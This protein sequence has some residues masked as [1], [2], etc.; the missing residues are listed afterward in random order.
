MSTCA[1]I[2]GPR[3]GRR[4][5]AVIVVLS[6][7][8]GAAGCGGGG[9]KSGT[10]KSASV[11]AT[12]STT[13]QPGTSSPGS[14]GHRH[15]SKKSAHTPAKTRTTSQ[16]HTTGAGASSTTAA[17]ASSNSSVHH[18]AASTGPVGP[19]HATL[20]APNHDPTANRGWT[21]SL[22]VKDGRGQPLSGTV[23]VEFA[24]GGKVVGRD[25]PPTHSF[26]NGEWHETLTYPTAAVAFPL[27]FRLVVHSPVGTT[28]IDW[29]VK[30]H[31]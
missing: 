9:A 31:R 3:T 1:Q 11:A 2:S 30:V 29:P 4:R 23:D 12:S 25:T 7:S 10:A 27:I 22:S 17:P 16:T 21:Y 18:A 15:A 19:L 5:A 26:H 8:I 20:S 28:T 14:H 13:T 24:F 6:V